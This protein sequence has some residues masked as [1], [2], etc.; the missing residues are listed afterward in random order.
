MVENYFNYIPN[1]PV[2]MTL[3]FLGCHFKIISF[4]Q[5]DKNQWR[6]NS[7]SAEPY[8]AIRYNRKDCKQAAI[9]QCKAVYYYFKQ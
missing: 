9:N 8:I 6:L 3:E 7:I 4:A 2:N 5:T 1:C